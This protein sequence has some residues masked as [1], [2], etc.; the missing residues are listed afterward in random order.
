MTVYGE[1]TVT[2]PQAAGEYSRRLA[3]RLL[4]SNRRR[5]VRTDVIA[6]SI[7]PLSISETVA[8][9]FGT[10]AG[11]PV[12]GTVVLTTGGSR[13]ASGDVQLLVSGPGSAA[14]FSITGEPGQTYALSYGNGTLAS[15]GGAQMTVSGFTDNAAGT[16]PGSSSDSFQV[17]ATLNVGS[18]QPAGNYSTAGGG[19]IPYTVTINYN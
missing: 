11:G 8:M 15:G 2:S 13:S 1:I 19:G 17:G 14:T 3:V 16:I 9:D 18:N 4:Q 6:T 7:V 12:P 5:R 10:I